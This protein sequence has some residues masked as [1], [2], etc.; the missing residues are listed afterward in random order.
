MTVG[1]MAIAFADGT[2]ANNASTKA[3][4]RLRIA[5]IAISS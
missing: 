5:F 1:K 3:E 2:A 4:Q